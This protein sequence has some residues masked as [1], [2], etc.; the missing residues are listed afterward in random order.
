M[1]C[2]K[3]GSSESMYCSTD[4]F[5]R[6]WEQHRNEAP[7]DKGT[8]LGGGQNGVPSLASTPVREQPGSYNSNGHSQ[9][10][11]M[12]TPGQM[13]KGLYFASSQNGFH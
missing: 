9:G 12:V 10:A 3:R 5:R 4:C 13:R 2:L 7:L 6:H 1:Q 11:G 8:G